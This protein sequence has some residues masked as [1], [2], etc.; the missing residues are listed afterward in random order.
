MGD[1]ESKPQNSKKNFGGPRKQKPHKI[2]EN[3][4]NRHL[5]YLKKENNLYFIS[6]PNLVFSFSYPPY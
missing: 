2:K 3:A 6:T 1:P 4:K 5:F